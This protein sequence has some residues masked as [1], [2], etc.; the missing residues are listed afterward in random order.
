MALPANKIKK[1]KLPNSTEAYEIIP[2]RLQNNGFEASLPTLSTN[3]TIALKSDVDNSVKKSGDSMSGNLNPATNKGASLGTSS[4]FWN[5]IYGTTLY[6]NGTSLVDKYANKSHTHTKSQITDF[7]HTHSKSEVGLGNV[8]DTSDADKPVSTAQQQALNLKANASDV[9]TKSD[10]DGLL[11]DKANKSDV[12]TKTETNGLLNDKANANNVYTKTEAD[13]LLNNKANK[14]DVYTKAETDTSLNNK[15]NKSDVYTKSETDNKINEP[16]YNLGAYDTITANSD[17]TYTITRQTGYYIFSG[18]ETWGFYGNSFWYTT[19]VGLI[20]SNPLLCSNGID[21]N[22]NTNDQIRVYLSSNPSIT[23]S[24]D[25]NSVFVNGVALQYKLATATTEKVEKNHYSRYNQRFILEHNKSEAERSANLTP[26]NLTTF[27]LNSSTRHL[28]AEN[29]PSGT[30]TL[31]LNLNTYNDGSQYIVYINDNSIGTYNNGTSATFTS[32]NYINSIKIYSND[33]GATSAKLMLNEGSTALPY[34]PYSGKVIHKKDITDLYENAYNLGYY[35]T[36]A[37]NSD[38]TYTITRQTGYTT[39]EGSNILSTFTSGGSKVFAAETNII[40]PNAVTDWNQ[41]FGTSNIGYKVVSVDGNWVFNKSI[42][43][44]GGQNVKIANN[45]F[46]TIDQFKSLCPINIQYKMTTSYT[47]KVEKNHY[48]TYNQRFILEHNKNEAERSAN[49]FDKNTATIGNGYDY[50]ATA[51][52]WVKAI[53]IP[54]EPNTTYTASSIISRYAFN[55]GNIVADYNKNTITTINDTKTLSLFM[56]VGSYSGTAR[57][58]FSNYMLN[59]GTIALPYQAY[60][61]NKHITNNEASFL[62]TEYDKITNLFD[63]D[64]AE[65]QNDVSLST[66]VGNLWNKSGSKVSTFVKVEPNKTYYIQNCALICCYNSNKEYL[67]QSFY[68]NYYSVNNFSFTTPS[69]CAYIRIDTEIP[70]TQIM[71][72]EGSVALPYQPYE[73]KVVH[74]KELGRYVTTDTSQEISNT[75]YFT[76]GLKVS[77]RY[78]EQGDDEGVIV[79]PDSNGNA[80]VCLGFATWKRSALIFYTDS[81]SSDAFWR[82]NDGV[83]SNCDIF[84]P[85]KSGTIAL[86]SDFKT[87]NGNSIV[88]SGDMAI[89]ADSVFTEVTDVI[90]TFT[91]NR[92]GTWLITCLGY[93]KIYASDNSSIFFYGNALVSMTSA[94]S[95]PHICINGTAY[96][97]SSA[98]TF[99]TSGI[100]QVYKKAN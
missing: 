97:C 94:G 80:V 3:S 8:N 29:L 18:T 90:D 12:Y 26:Y 73:G 27:P 41:E 55:H 92:N 78:H 33:A 87:I 51:S 76:K 81:S 4:L 44:I 74:E 16:L 19:I 52:D 84:H 70:I 46:T 89:T 24:T 56:Y 7:S 68:I 9:Y 72:N 6:E 28:I 62:K 2:E 23:S 13:G 86:T 40:L 14:S 66:Q 88:G 37:A 60:N 48:A 99:I 100:M 1:I 59:K 34:Q 21:V 31:S 20:K 79:A 32:N 36:I 71:L 63:Y 93:N 69:N 22:C 42:G 53:D 75:K 83:G 43:G 10:T 11:N 30:Y 5:N 67:N 39:I 38:G 61:Q 25:M 15:A 95:D 54:V 45:D 49:I 85:K 77:G 64:N 50:T 96:A 98:I 17:G 91:I 57:E 58:W 82:F 35:D 47:E 65:W